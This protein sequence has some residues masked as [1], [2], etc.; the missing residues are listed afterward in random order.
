M[1]MLD[2]IPTP[3]RMS[4]CAW[5]CVVVLVVVQTV[6]MVAEVFFWTCW[7]EYVCVARDVG[8]F[9]GDTI[10]ATQFLGKNMGLYNGFLAAG[11]FWSLREPKGLDA[12]LAFFFAS[13]V[14]VAGV[15][16]ALTVP[17]PDG[18]IMLLIGQGLFA[19][20]ALVALFYPA[21][22]PLSD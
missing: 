11:L 17:V 14:L 15:V 21:I 1:Q 3:T 4:K 18:K 12:R 10:S 5:C 8:G 2:C 13:C 22:C 6:A 19:A 7:F 16:G 9:Q 20:C